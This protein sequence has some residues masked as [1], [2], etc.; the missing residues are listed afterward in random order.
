MTEFVDKG[1]AIDVIFLD[2]SK[3][4]NSLQQY[5]CIPRLGCCDLDE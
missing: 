1:R 4:F 3:V 2:F 5:S